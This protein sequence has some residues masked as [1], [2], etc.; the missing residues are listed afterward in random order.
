MFAIPQPGAYYA[1]RL[2]EPF[3][4]FGTVLQA[5]QHLRQIHQQQ[6]IATQKQKQE[7]TIFPVTIFPPKTQETEQVHPKTLFEIWLRRSQ[8]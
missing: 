6:Q 8:D 5:P 4:K 2:N 1:R 3:G 7:H